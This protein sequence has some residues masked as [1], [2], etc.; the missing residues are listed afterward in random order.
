[1]KDQSQ[2]DYLRV[3]YQIIEQEKDADVKSVNI[4][5][6]LNIS[7]AAVSK[8]L[9]VL[10]AQGLV[11]IELYSKVNLTKKGFLIARKLTYKHRVIE[12][13]LKDILNVNKD[14]IEREAHDLEHAFSD[15]TIKKLADF[16]NNP[17]ICP[18]GKK[19]TA[20]ND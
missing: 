13:F 3:I 10:Q 16:L 17:K 1:M 5:T 18:C 19:I 20:I 4:A 7:K 11:S 12:V 15:K 8:M 2:E 14:F 9:K 6:R